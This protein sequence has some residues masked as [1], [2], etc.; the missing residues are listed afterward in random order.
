MRS[1]TRSRRRP[2]L[3]PPALLVLSLGIGTA[4][5]GIADVLRSPKF[6]R[7]GLAPIAPVLA[8]TVASTYPVASASSGVVYTYNPELDTLERQVGVAGPILGERAE[9]I[10]KG[11]FTFATSY[12]YVHL[13]TINGD[14]MDSLLNRPRVNGQTLIFPVKPGDT[15]ADGRFT[16]FLPVRVV[17]DIDV[18]AHIAAPS[19]TYGVTPDLDVNL[20]VPLLYTSLGVTAHTRVPDPR[21]PLFALNPGDPNAQAGTRSLSD[22][23]VGIGDV[24]LRAKYMLLRSDWMDVA[25]QL[26]LSL[27]TGSPGNLQGTGTTRLLPI[28]VLSHVFGNRFEPFLNAGVDVNANDVSRSVV[29]WGVGATAQIVDRFSTTVAFFGRNELAAQAE[30]I[31]TPFF[32]QIERNDIYDASVGFRWR[33]ADTG[34][35][36]LNALVPL[37]EDGFRP[38]VVPTLEVEYSF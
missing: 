29:R 34:F 26:G 25:A 27:P 2:P 15:L 13:A 23:A 36:G 32:F 10:G 35:V 5:G 28:L 11:I 17:A 20:T 16:T 18:Q 22:N 9:T 19:L 4:W 3:L 38:S 6:D 7:L 33:F 24:L 8:D 14:D 30:P 21:F 37:N 12:S 31:K 1:R